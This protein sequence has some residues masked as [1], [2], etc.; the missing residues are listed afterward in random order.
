MEIKVYLEKPYT[1]EQRLDFIV[2]NNHNSGY[3][4]RE[5][6]EE[7]Q[8]WGYTAEEIAE[9]EAAA[10]AARKAKLK[11]TK[12]DFFLYVLKPYNVTYGALMTLLSQPQFDTLKACY[13]GCNH[14]YRY[15]QNFMGNIK[16]MLEILTGQTIDEQEL[17]AFLDE[18][19]EEHNATD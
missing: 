4:I 19:F 13:E 1:E 16:A 12:Q 6:E 8:A 5:T 3:E 7:L 10:E 9:Q 14:I 18:Q 17:L 15:D 2:E 11:M